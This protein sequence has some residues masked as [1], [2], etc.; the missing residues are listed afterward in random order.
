MLRSVKDTLSVCAQP[1]GRRRLAAGSRRLACEPLEPRLVLDAGPLLI[2]EFM[3]VNDTVLADADGQYSDWI[4]IHNP[5]TSAVNLDGWYL[6]DDDGDLTKWQLPAMSLDPNDYLVVFASGKDV[7]NP[8]ELHTNFRLSG[9][10][11][12]LA[13]VQPDGST[14]S[15][16]YAPEFPEQYADMSYG[17]TKDIQSLVPAGAK[18]TYHVPTSGDAALGADWTEIDFD[19][20]GWV[21]TDPPPPLQITEVSTDSDDWVEIQNVSDEVLDTSGWAVAANYP[22]GGVSGVTSVLWMLPDALDPGEVLYQTDD[23]DD[24]DNYWGANLSWSTSGAGWVMVV[25]DVGSVVDFVAWRYNEAQL[26]PLSVDVNGFTITIEDIWEGAGAPANTGPSQSLQRSGA[27]DHDNASDWVFAPAPTMGE[28]NPDL[29]TPFPSGPSTGLGFGPDPQGVAG[30]VRTD[31][32]ID[33]RGENASLWTRI[34]FEVDDLTMLT[35]LH[36]WMKYEDGFVAYINGVEVASRNAPDSPVWNSAA[37][38]DRDARDAVLYED[39]DLTDQL[40]VLQVGQNLLAIHGLNDS[41]ADDEFLILP[42]MLA[43][44]DEDVMRYMAVPTPWQPNETA[45]AGAGPSFSRTGGTFTDPFTLELSTDSA[46][47]TIRYTLDGTNP[48]ATSPI[49]NLP[50]PVDTSTQVRAVV[51]E[52]STG[53]SPVVIESYIQLGPDVLSFSSQLPLVIVDTFGRGIGAGIFQSAY[54]AIFE[55]IDGVATLTQLTDLDTRI[56]IKTRGSSSGS[57]P[58]HHYGVEA[59]NSLD[60]DQDISP[61]G[62]PD[63]SDWILS[64]FYQFD[65]ALMRNPLIYELSRQAG[66]WA[67][68]TQYCEVFVN[69][70]TGPVSYA[71]YHGVY[72]FM[73]K[74]KRDP[75]RVDIEGLDPI[76]EHNVEPDVT[77][78]YILKIDRADPGDSGFSV[79][80][81]TYM[82]VEPKEAEI[83]MANRS[84]QASYIRNFINRFNT[85]AYSGYFADPEIGFRAYIDV[86][87]WIDHWWLNTMPKNADAFRLSG[88]MYKDRNG[89][90]MGGPLWDFDRSMESTDDRDNTWN[91]WVGGTDYFTFGWWDRLFLDPDFSQRWVDR[92]FELRQ[93]VLST[94]NI[95]A[96]MDSYVAEIGLVAAARN[97]ARWPEVSPRYGSWMGEVNHLRDWLD[98]RVVWIDGR[99]LH[100]VVFGQYGGPIDAGFQLSLSAPVGTVYYT[101][102]GS[103]PRAPGGSVAPNALVYDGTPITLDESVRIKARAWNGVPLVVNSSGPSGGWSA[104]VEAE[105]FVGE[106]ASAANLVITE[107]NYDPYDATPD[108]RTAGFV[109]ND[110]FEFIELRNMADAPIYLGGARFTSGIEFDFSQGGVEML[111]PGQYVIVAKDLA[112]FEA[113]YGAASNVVGGY[114]QNLS[115]GGEQVTLLDY[116]DRPIVDFTYDNGGAWPGRAA[117]KGASLELIDPDAVPHVEPQRSDYLGD[118]DAWRSSSEYGGTPGSAGLGPLGSVVIN[119]VLSHTDAPWTDTLELHNLTDAAIDLG[120]WFLSDSDGNFQKFRIPDGTLIPAGGY[121]A[122]DEDDFNPTPLNPGPNDFALN[123]AHGD[124]VWLMKGDALGK[125]THF[126]DHVDFPAQGNGESWGRWPNG[127]GDFCPMSVKT[128]DPEH[129]ENS[130]PRVGPVLL[131]EVHYNPGNFVGANEL[132]FVEVHNSSGEAVDLTNWRIRRGIDFDFAEGTLLAPGATAV[133]VA[134]D[135]E[136]GDALDSFRAYHGV[137]EPV[138]IFGPYSGQLNNGGDVVQLQRPDLPPLDEP[139]FIPYLLEDEI[140]YDDEGPWPPGADGNGQSLNRTAVNV[141]GND[142]ASWN[143]YPPTPGMAPLLSSAGVVD[144]HIF[145]NESVFDGNTAAVNAQDDGAIAADKQALLPGETAT[146]ANYTSYDRGINGIMVDIAGLPNPVALGVDD[147]RFHA[148]N[149]GNPE[150]WGVAPAPS[151]VAVRPGEGTGGT[152]RVTIVWSDNA[153]A[154][155]WLQVTVL[156]NADTALPTDDVFYFGNAVGEAGNSPA[157]ARVNATDMLLA[158]NNPRDFLNPAPIDFACDFNRDARVNATDMLIAR[159]HVTHFLNALSLI[160]VP[161][162]KAA[163]RETSLYPAT[164]PQEALSKAWLY[165]LERMATSQPSPRSDDSAADIVDELMATD[166][167]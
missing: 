120:G 90:L 76:P 150:A 28:P 163:E 132:E 157:D 45:T 106:A 107:L 146:F 81:L 14:I 112:A 11:E 164:A 153:V 35:G 142:P 68:R 34:P 70:G 93:E 149:D 147:F 32:G 145:Y 73:E 37:T 130:S 137:E 108:E 72:A 2:S 48:T 22:S 57:W 65:R 118:A 74:I 165:E 21:G 1:A 61:F 30:A 50:I 33:M 40:G 25:D 155:Q 42:R 10:G 36:L 124:D 148:G 129:G 122:F 27:A 20:T 128:F 116:L 83:E 143:D 66:S 144:R 41:A 121:V 123:G 114:D 58:K 63:E 126:A 67:S 161:G 64:S 136:D 127:S 134:F 3:A 71:D 158:R 38:T 100:P 125:L 16:Q 139:D 8:A 24:A 44:S 166:W 80:G 54:M 91:N 104:P 29:V 43:S 103:D 159:N 56:G 85:A 39:I 4:E 160:T 115:N 15:H 98:N 88:Y 109:D 19:N 135:P 86:E 9:G 62:L 133:V 162:A 52:D 87:S 92:W 46:S 6:T 96:V 97:F 5:T 69:T 113:R 167:P 78:G 51:Y 119:E 12:Y 154:G 111:D 105:F 7:T 89:L 18:V 59:W 151:L 101:L 110:D 117:G 60:Q 102:D 31:V 13:L 55:Q 131:S 99:F 26:A 156:A 94:E 75:E 82:Y 84:G 49:Y 141:W 152:D 79:G 17:M 140:D 95:H 138:A 47:G 53:P 23:T 77:G